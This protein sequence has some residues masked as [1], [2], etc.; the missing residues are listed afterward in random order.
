MSFPVSAAPSAFASSRVQMECTKQSTFSADSWSRRI[1]T[2]DRPSCTLT[3]SR[4][5]HLRDVFYHALRVSAVQTW[6]HFS[7]DLIND[8]FYSREAK[9]TLCVLG[10]VA[11]VPDFTVADD[12]VALVGIPLP[13]TQEVMS[14]LP[15]VSYPPAEFHA[16]E[17]TST[18]ST[19]T[20]TTLNTTVVSVTGDGQLTGLTPLTAV[21]GM[22][23]T[24]REKPGKFDAW[25]LRFE[26]QT[27]YDVA[28]QMLGQLPGVKFSKKP[29]QPGV[30]AHAKTTTFSAGRVGPLEMM[31]KDT[32]KHSRRHARPAQPVQQQQ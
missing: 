26:S 3:V 29:S 22:G 2:V 27:A 15:E 19:T 10:T 17:P 6:P 13:N 20:T 24:R 18:I 28:V 14:A 23:K 30:G 32:S 25:V 9:L 5:H 31:M 1:L 21:G 16:D 11:A 7:L 8:D 12:A 4:H